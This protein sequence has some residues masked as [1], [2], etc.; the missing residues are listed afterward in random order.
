MLC[1][2]QTGFVLSILIFCFPESDMCRP[3]L[4]C[5]VQC[6]LIDPGY[7]QCLELME[8]VTFNINFAHFSVPASVVDRRECLSATAVLEC[9]FCP[10][11][12]KI[13]S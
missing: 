11:N 13:S 9:F 1:W 7:C 6:M 2:A 12:L 5:W 10:R 3:L 4:W 8:T